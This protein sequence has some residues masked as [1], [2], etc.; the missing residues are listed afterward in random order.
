MCWIHFL[1]AFVSNFA[2]NMSTNSNWILGNILPG[3][4]LILVVKFSWSLMEENRSFKRETDTFHIFSILNI[5]TGQK[6]ALKSCVIGCLLFWHKSFPIYVVFISFETEIEKI[7]TVPASAQLKI[8]NPSHE[9]SP[10][11]ISQGSK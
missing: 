8:S 5:L 9:S 10:I 1:T 4:I 2:Q 11:N 6:N 7:E 3:W